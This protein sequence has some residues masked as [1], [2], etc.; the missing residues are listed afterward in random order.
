MA[1]RI[2]EF[3]L[4]IDAMMKRMPD[5]MKAVAGK[6]FP[7]FKSLFH[8]RDHGF[9]NIFSGFFLLPDYSPST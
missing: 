7:L 8:I 1:R 2:G 4:E 5:Y 9:F 6:A 3:N